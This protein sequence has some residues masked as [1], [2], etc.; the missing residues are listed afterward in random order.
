M[1]RK[2]AI[3]FILNLTLAVAAAAQSS[4]WDEVYGGSEFEESYSV[5]TA[6]DSSHVVI[7]YT[8]SQGAGGSDLALLKIGYDGGL[9]WLKT[10]GGMGSESGYDV[11]VTPDSDLVFVGYST[12]FS[13]SAQAYIIRTD[14]EGN[15][16][17]SRVYGGPADD[18]G[19][20]IVQDDD[21][22]FVIA[23][24]TRSFG[25]GQSDVYLTKLTAGGSQLWTKFYG[26]AGMDWA[27]DICKT[28]DGFIVVGYTNSY[29]AGSYDTYLLRLDADCDTIWTRSYG[30]SFLEGGEAVVA[31][32]V[33]TYLIGG[34][35]RG[36]VPENSDALLQCV[37]QSGTLLWE[38]LTGGTADDRISDLLLLPDGR[39]IAVG[40]T[41][42]SGSGG[43]DFL[44]VK[45]DTLGDSL[46]SA[47]YGAYL[48]DKA[49]AVA[50]VDDEGVVIA[51]YSASFGSL[52]QIY[53]VRADHDFICGDM[54]GSGSI[55]ISD[56]VFLIAWIFGAGRAPFPVRSAD[57][58]C[59]GAPNLSDVVALI[60]WIF[61]EGAGPCETC[62]PEP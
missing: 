13:P 32:E 42:S 61:G 14:L 60:A 4:V 51:G 17:W 35:S 54:D 57:Y 23:G 9:G 55:T 47:T 28:N 39:A 25:A 11:L 49:R 30:T 16:D 33:G 26:G 6:P 43:S 7:G 46:A 31:T 38:K 50:A 1:L 3:F 45:I 56:G 36:G 21:G 59:S 20:A 58:D 48:A 19:Y 52:R 34:V 41:G 2:L 12:S 37:D 8:M 24:E 40:E 10:F 22:G 62:S 15:H 53:V 5:V 27:S 44:Y 29:G 18:Y